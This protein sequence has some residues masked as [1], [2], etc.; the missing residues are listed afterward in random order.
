MSKITAMLLICEEYGNSDEEERE[1]KTDD[2]YWSKPHTG[3]HG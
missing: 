1:T 2:Q 3:L